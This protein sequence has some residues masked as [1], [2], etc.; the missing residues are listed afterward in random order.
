MRFWEWFW[1]ILKT[2]LRVGS[3][4]GGPKPIL[5][6]SKNGPVWATLEEEE[7]L[8]KRLALLAAF[9]PSMNMIATM[10]ADE[11]NDNGE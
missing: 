9:G 5:E 7:N 10:L 8:E 2:T 3:T 6:S 1:G 11:D 4:H